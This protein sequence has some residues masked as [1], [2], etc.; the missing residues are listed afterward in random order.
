MRILI[1]LP[2]ALSLWS[3]LCGCGNPKPP[4]SIV[5]C[6]FTSSVDVESSSAKIK[7]DATELLRRIGKTD[8]IEYYLISKNNNSKILFKSEPLDPDSRPTDRKE[9]EKMQLKLADSLKFLL[10]SA[11]AASLKL[12]PKE[13]NSCIIECIERAIRSFE[14][15]D[16][17]NKAP[18]H[19]YILS[20]MLE[21]CVFSKDEKINLEPGNDIGKQFELIPKVTDSNLSF[22]RFKN[23]QV[24]I[25]ISTL[26]VLEGNKRNFERFWELVF[27]RYGYDVRNRISV[28]L[29]RVEPTKETF[30]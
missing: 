9:F 5:F 21:C 19:L 27:E 1:I 15:Y 28:D 8:V 25:V 26:K 29:P 4:C 13:P 12:Y 10:D 3:F 11:S 18:L 6:D 17:D 20:D 16:D 22:R 14:I 23:V 30:W 2:L 24:H 7:A